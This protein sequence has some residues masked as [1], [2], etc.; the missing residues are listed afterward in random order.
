MKQTQNPVL[1]T[2]PAA[3]NPIA[4]SYKTWVRDSAV[5]ALSLDAAGHHA[6]ADKFFR[7]LAG[8]QSADGSFG[9]TY[10]EWTGQFISF[11]QPESDSIGIFVIGVLRHYVATGDSAFLSAMWPAVQKAAGFIQS[12]TGGNGFGPADHSIWEEDLEYNSFTQATYVAGLWAAEQLAADEG[13]TTLENSWAGTASTISAALNRDSGASP[14]GMWNSVGGGYFDRAVN[15]DNT[16]RV[17]PVDSSSDMLLVLG[18]IDSASSKAVS[19]VAKI[20][21]TLAQD[22]WGI[23]RYVGDTFYYTSQ[24]SP[25]G[26]EALA[27]EPSWPQMSMY[28]ALD[29]I[30]T[31]DKATA[32]DRLTWYASRTATGYMPPGEATSN[33]SQKP[34]VSTMVEPVTGA[35][36]VLAALQYGGQTDTRVYA[37]V[38]P[39]GDHAA[40]SVTTGTTGD[41]PQW[42]Q[43]PY[44]TAT[45]PGGTPADADTVVR[46]VAP[47]NDDANV[48]LRIDNTSGSLP[49]YQAAPEFGV[50]VYSADFT[51]AAGTATTTTGIDG[52]KLARPV[53]YLVVR[54]SGD[55]RYLRY[56]VVNGAWVQGA[57]VTGVIAPQW[58][59]ADGRVELAVPRAALA[60]GAT[61]N[62]GQAPMVV[63]LEHRSAATSKWTAD[64]STTLLYRLTGSSTAP[65]AANTR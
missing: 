27:A 57:D 26:N 15:T 25:A 41:W 40:I 5:T 64:S 1:G 43:V 49:A 61:A 29:E 60:S 28:L 35:W 13:D 18:V 11:V 44:F 19:H 7:W 51:G 32:L 38:A 53:S 30:F 9:T 58:D 16:A 22:T 50:D 45:P 10:D 55:D 34:I 4:Y 33:V 54:R 48:Y 63:E 17:D 31:G 21:S 62:G 12:G 65:V 46:D 3:T 36:Y 39:A 42:N 6:E 24:Y 14:A 56:H 23:A 20:S 37:P 47:A 2:W 52:E 59:P 8:I